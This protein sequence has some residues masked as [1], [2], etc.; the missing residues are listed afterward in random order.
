GYAGGMRAVFEPG[1]YARLAAAL[2]SG[3]TPLTASNAAAAPYASRAYQYDSQQRVT[4]EVVAGV[5]STQGTGDGRGTV[6]YAYSTSANAD[7]YNAWK[8][9]TVETRPDGETNT[10][11]TNYIGRTMLWVKA[12][13]SAGQSFSGKRLA[14]FYQYDAAGRL[15]MTA[16]PS[17]FKPDT[18]GNLWDEAYADLL[19][20][21]GG[22]DYAY[23]G[24]DFG[25]LDLT[26]Y[27]AATTATAT[28]A[29][30]VTGLPTAT[31]TRRG[32]RAGSAYG[33]DPIQ[34]SATQYYL[35]AYT[36]TG[37]GG[38]AMTVTPV[39]A[40]S[41][42]PDAVE[43]TPGT[44]RTTDY[45][46][47]Y[48]ASSVK[49]ES[50]TVQQPVVSTGR[51]GPGGSTRDTDA[52]Y[53][54][55]YGHPTWTKDAGGYLGYTATD[56]VTGAATTAIADV[57][58]AQTTTFAGKP[59]GWATPAGG[60]L[61]LTTLVR[62]DALGR[63]T[64]VT[65]PNGNTSYTVYKD[66][67]HE[68]RAYR[69]WNPTTHTATGPTEIVREYRP[70]ANAAS[71]QR[72][73]YTETLTTSATAAY[74][75]TTNEPTGT[76]APSAANIQSLSRAVTNSSGQVTDALAYYSLAGVTYAAATALLG[77]AGNDSASGNY[78]R[79]Q[80]K[81]DA[82]GRNSVLVS[83]TGT[84]SRT[85]FDGFG[86]AAAVYVGTNDA[87][88]TDL[89]PDG[90]GGTNNL[91]KVS[92]AEYDQSCGCPNSSGDGR[93]TKVTTYPGGG[94]A[95][96][97][98][99]NYYDWRGRLVATKS[100]VQT[101]EADDNAHPIAYADLNNLGQITAS[102]AYDG[103]GVAVTETAGVPVKPSASLLRAETVTSYDEQLRPYRTQTYSVDPSSGSVSSNALTT[104]VFYDRRGLLVETAAPGGLV[105]K[106]TIDGAGRVTAAYSTDG[107]GDAGWA[108][109]DDVAGDAVLEQA[110][111]AYD[112]DGNAVLTTAR[113]RFHDATATGALG[114]PGS[115]TA[116]KARVYYSAGYYDAADRPTASVDVGTDGGTAYTRPGSAPAR[117]DTALVTSYAYDAA[118]RVQDVTDPR[119]L[120]TRTA[121]DLL[122][123]TT[124]ATENYVDGTPSAADDRITRYTYDGV[125]H[126]LTMTADLPS[127]QHDQTTQYVYGVTTAGGST[128]ASNG[129]LKE[130]RYPDKT[131]GA[132][133]TASTDKEQYTYDAAGAAKTFTDRNG[134]VHTYGYD[135]LGRTLT[136]AVTTLATGVDG[137][138]RRLQTAYD[139]QGNAALL[140]SYDAAT[141][142]NVVN[143]VARAFNGLGQ[144]TTEY[145]AHAGAVSPPATP[146]VQYAYTEMASGANHSRLTGM[147]YPDGRVL[148]YEYNSGLDSNI[149]RVSTL[150]DDSP[151]S[152]GTHLADY[153][154]LG[155]GTIV[156]EGRPENGTE[157]TYVKR[158]GESDG[159][160]GDPYT[161]LDRFGR[162]V[163]QRWLAT[164]S[165]TAT[166]RFRYGYDRDGNPLYKANDV[167]PG[168]SELYHANGAGNG[169][170]GLNRLAEFRRG[171]LTDGNAD[172]TPD[173]V[174]TGDLSAL[175]GASRTWGL[176]ALGNQSST[177]TDGTT[178]TRTHDDRNELTG[179]GSA[180]LAFDANGN[181][182]TDQRGQTLTYDAWNRLASVTTGSST[183]AYKYDV[184]GRRVREAAGAAVTDL[185]YTA[186][187][188][189]AQETT[190]GGATTQ[191]VWGLGYVDDLVARDRDAD[192]NAATG[193]YGQAGSG[194]EERL[195]A[196]RDANHNVTALTDVSGAVVQRFVYDPYGRSTILTAVGA[197]TSGGYDWAY[198]FQGGR[199]NSITGHYSFRIR[200]YDP[201]IERWIQSDP[202]VYID[203]LNTYALESASPTKY[204]DPNGLSTVDAECWNLIQQF[205]NTVESE[206]VLRKN[207]QDDLK[208]E[209][210]LLNLARSE[211]NR[212]NSLN[213]LRSELQNLREWLQT[214]LDIKNGTNSAS[215]FAAGG[216]GA[217]LMTN[218]IYRG[219]SLGRKLITASKVVS[220][221]GI[222][223]MIGD[224]VVDKIYEPK[225]VI[226]KSA[227]MEGALATLGD[228]AIRNAENLTDRAEEARDRAKRGLK[229]ADDMAELATRLAWKIATYCEE[230][231][232][233]EK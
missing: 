169:Y 97:V 166:D 102:Y 10:V 130:V 192:A 60:G 119:G 22:G 99:Q 118:G 131:T 28:A 134:T 57:D 8:T 2:P 127:G 128:I 49:V 34:Q 58:S 39:A 207:A 174:A 158:S 7:G 157:L 89:D 64:K 222:A 204:L 82:A 145:Q 79:T 147:T 17:A 69:G 233:R 150:A 120:V 9:K 59:T 51:N 199:L 25:Q 11:Y 154:Y 105:S 212:A 218:I 148:R 78:H 186:G 87:G 146:T 43:G 124:S 1:Q 168:L 26:A 196:Q 183:A 201:S 219:N 56:P 170:D 63:P 123:R 221:V 153:S 117:S 213:A 55:A 188:Q 95:A 116:P 210:N 113:Q 143:Q 217:L 178:T 214:A 70:A 14:T 65:D 161:G 23:L 125:D 138:V 38:V 171:A 84:I 226:V 179:I 162:V 4:Q 159:D 41:V 151:G 77:T 229:A 121:Y 126:V 90:S 96:R 44:A 139:T 52:M 48:F 37:T 21:Q 182:T 224:I 164:S 191:Y 190:S 211:V 140:T 135:V 173:T 83:P 15:V 200:D 103:D 86:N 227:Q 225:K 202:S 185:Y 223:V 19:H 216:G 232:K 228:E 209:G 75:A 32:D 24:D 176:D 133:G 46:Y 208:L 189:V 101:T 109:A 91:V 112:A 108:D 74:N 172:G 110:E 61:H 100:G 175:S 73:V 114:D 27:A 220:G 184:L 29:G 152:V 76:E 12:D 68:V 187:W 137:A 194:R 181:T 67:A 205:E 80:S 13:H 122:D 93:A 111:Y 215:R 230:K 45:A 18:G 33:G 36:P 16:H 203:G 53:F 94:A 81:Y 231:A 195:Y 132:A 141:G 3:T 206:K 35:Q 107:G 62:V 167:L 163:D 155:L 66:A 177:S 72:A 31:Y 193:G 104:N 54:D 136:D 5:G 42:Y 160:A 180:T 106:A 30:D 142:G 197:A 156:R 129:L 149:S 6:T 144:L 115:T 85:V 98:T 198:Q 50:V 88:A 71:G 40:E 47:T 20:D 165:G 92:E